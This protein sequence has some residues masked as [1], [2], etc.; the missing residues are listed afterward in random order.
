MTVEEFIYKL[1][2]F[3][4]GEVSQDALPIGQ[5]YNFEWEHDNGNLNIKLTINE[6]AFKLVD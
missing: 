6:S 3:L 5:D 2:Q 4:Q 1:V